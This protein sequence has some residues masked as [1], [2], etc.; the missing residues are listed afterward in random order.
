MRVSQS[1]QLLPNVSLVLKMTLVLKCR[2]SIMYVFDSRA[3]QEYIIH[4]DD[5]MIPYVA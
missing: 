5:K 4:S 1:A 3:N 2:R